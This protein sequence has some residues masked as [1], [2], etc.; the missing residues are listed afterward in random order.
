MG[1]TGPQGL[2]G[3][4]GPTGT[5]GPANGLNVFGGLY[6]NLEAAFDMTANVPSITQMPFT[7]SAKGV[8]YAISDSITVEEAGSYYIAYSLYAR[9]NAPATLTFAVR[10]NGTNIIPATNTVTV[11]STDYGVNH[12]GNT[13]AELPANAIIDI[14]VT[15]S[16]NQTMTFNDSSLVSLNIFKLD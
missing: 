2:Q 12:A 16:V 4:T 3:D 13:I 1:P 6:N 15:S 14:A 8:S 10:I 7:T 11:N 5:T 9:F